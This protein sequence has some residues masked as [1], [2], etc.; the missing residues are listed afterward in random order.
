MKINFYIPDDF[1]DLE[2]ELEGYPNSIDASFSHEYGVMSFEPMLALEDEPTWDE[3]KYS[4]EQNDIINTYIYNN[5]SKI[6]TT[7]LKHYSL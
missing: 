5:Y 3:D 7:F 6:E 4:D 2:V 1:E